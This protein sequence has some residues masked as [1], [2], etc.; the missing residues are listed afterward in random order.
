MDI[1]PDLSSSLFQRLASLETGQNNNVSFRPISEQ[2][3]HLYDVWFNDGLM[4]V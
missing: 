3:A 1:K 2:D 4:M